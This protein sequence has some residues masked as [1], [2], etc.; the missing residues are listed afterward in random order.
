MMAGKWEDSVGRL[1]SSFM[2]A[3]LWV[4]QAVDPNR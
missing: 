2:A 3:S 1:R 4:L